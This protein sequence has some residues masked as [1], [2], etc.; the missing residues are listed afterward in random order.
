MR[1]ITVLCAAALLAGASPS[2]LAATTA[3]R[4]QDLEQQIQALSKQVE[5]LKT[6]ASQQEAAVKAEQEAVK[7]QQ[8]EVQ[9]QQAA[10]KKQA[11]APKAGIANG[12]LS[13][14]SADGNFTAAVRGLLQVDAGAYFQQGSAASL[15]AAYGPDLS[16]GT[17]L[18]RVFLGLQGKVFGDWSYYFLYDFGGPAVETQGH[19]LYAYVQYDGLAPWAF[20]IGA[21]APPIN[22]EDQ[23][24]SADLMFFERNSPSN[25]QRGIAGAEG[26]DAVSVLYTGQRLFGALS[27]TGGKVQEGAKALGGG[28][29][30]Y[31]EQLA[32]VGRLSY[33]PISTDDAH[34]IVGVNGLHVFQLQK[35]VRTGAAS[36]D[37]TPG[38]PAKTSFA[39]GDLP[40][41]SVDSNGTKLIATPTMPASHV[42]SWGMETAA[43]YKNFYGQAGYYAYYVNRS[44][45]AYNVYSAPSVYAPSIVQPGDNQFSGWYVQGS[46]IL[47]GE[48][49]GYSPASGSFTAPKPAKPFSLKDGGW[50]AFELVARF[51]DTNLNDRTNDASNV[52]TDW[53]PTARSYTYYNTVRGGEQKIFTFGINW[54][55]NA[56]IRTSLDYQYIDIS[57][58]QTPGVVTTAGTPS[59]P[60]LNG[61]QTLSTVAFRTQLVL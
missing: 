61:G 16:S 36:L 21:Y 13:V 18:R 22:I 27:L 30:Q 39:I 5:E 19:I 7:Q 24:S 4:I 43:N 28:T 2:A 45:I 15:P 41:F 51:S 46:W 12:R 10:F 59:L 38:A 50:G 44:P 11:S 47:T 26:R 33:L 23:T 53:T 8:A 55:L 42:S 58:L 57:R 25:I 20:R 31:G 49:R 48:Q 14:S 1:S 17:N 3:S 37:T 6:S 34:W 54:Y 56:V 40:E 29:A 52:V 9:S 35:Y 32:V 60:M